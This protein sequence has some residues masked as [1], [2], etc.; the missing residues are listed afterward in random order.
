M[1]TLWV[2]RSGT[3]AASGEHARAEDFGVFAP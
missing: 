2:V 3:A 1:E